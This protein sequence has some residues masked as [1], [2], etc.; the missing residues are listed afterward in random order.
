MR[1]LKDPKTRMKV[2][3]LIDLIYLYIVLINCNVC[4]LSPIYLF[5]SASDGDA[6]SYVVEDEDSEW[7]GDRDGDESDDSIA[8]RGKKGKLGRQEKFLDVGSV[9]RSS[10]KARSRVI[11]KFKSFWF[12]CS[13]VKF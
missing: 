10:R 12:Y 8:K 5:L 2:R 13:R 4:L 6:D 1:I 3:K 9:R 11:C 7:S